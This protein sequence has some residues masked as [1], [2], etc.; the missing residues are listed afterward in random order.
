MKQRAKL[1]CVFISIAIF[2]TATQ[3]LSAAA[4][5]EPGNIGQRLENAIILYTGSS[6]A[7]VDNAY[8]KIDTI[9]DKVVPF[10][11]NGIR[12]VP[13]RFVAENLGGKVS[14]YRK[15]STAEIRYGVKRI[16]LT[17]GS[18][19]MTVD[20]M[21]IKLSAPVDSVDGRLFVPLTQFAGV[22]DREVFFD[23]GLIVISSTKDFFNVISDRALIN[24]IIA[25][26]NVLPVVGSFEKLK[27]LV[28]E[29]QGRS[30]YF[31]GD[32]R[33]E[34]AEMNISAASSGDFSTTNIQ[35]EGV[36][37]ADIVKT[38][39]E[40]IYQVNKQ[41]IVVAKAYPAES[42]KVASIINFD[43][44]NFIP[45]ELYLY[46]EK[47]V[48]I[49]SSYSSIPEY[50]IYEKAKLQIYP[51]DRFT[52]STVKAVI[53]D[54]QDKKNIKVLRQIELDGNYLSSRMVGPS[55]YLTAN[56]YMNLYYIQEGKDSDITPFYRDSLQKNDFIN[57]DFSRIYYF[58]GML[59]ANYLIIAGLNLDNDDQ[60]AKVTAYLGA[61]QNIFASKENLYVALT[62]M[63]TVE[64]SS[65][66]MG[67]VKPAVMPGIL[68]K[69]VNYESN[70]LVYKFSLNGDE[71]IYLGRGEVPGTILNQF[72]MDEYEGAFRIATTS[73]NAWRND[74]YMSKNNV[75]I[76]DEVLGL[77]GKIEDIAPGE[78]IY[79]V[80]FM[81]ERGYMVTFRTV[82]PLFVIDLKDPKSPK[83]LGSLKIPG[84]SD[85]IHP[86]DENHIIGFGKD[87]TE[88]K[89]N[90]YYLGMKIALF[91]VSDVKNPK[92]EFSEVIG[93]RGTDSELLRNHRAL[94]FSKSKNLLAFPVTV[95]K[96]GDKSD[97]LQ[98]G[99]F[100]F[101][102]AYVYNID[103]VSGFALKARISH[104]SDED[105]LKSGDYWY[106]SDKNI[107]RIMY[108]NDTLYTLSKGM[109]KANGLYD[110]KEKKV[111]VIPQN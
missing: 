5:S 104:L 68:I 32:L 82:D 4:S 107:E 59:D 14:W 1:I 83:I 39:G 109:L 9:S 74:K 70:T 76:L 45:M 55:L 29:S 26:V 75:Y 71:V 81:G 62:G 63:N 52:R 41:K 78:K 25:R 100:E 47:L 11:R 95:L 10:I 20:G 84:Y 53:Y 87:T 15:T 111:I 30:M 44:R 35:V 66:D 46:K 99:E 24:Q 54:I 85:Y 98:Y 61:G 69:P 12:F 50:D 7:L 88:I 16:K 2:L 96:A 19:V 34:K 28:E 51:P 102:G 27:S 38:D 108:I 43:D 72:S 90:A 60:A 13:V 8:A 6:S 40:Y 97:S 18:D 37:E 91:D 49:G 94:L 21:K 17:F 105:Y 64:E 3:L 79:A 65:A 67:A 73:G 31:N 101:Q 56:R 89:S 93:D 106:D 23:R 58:P 86:Y 110:M 36:D 77:T 80:R 57:I 33:K 22:F 48:V 42:M 92:Q 103:L